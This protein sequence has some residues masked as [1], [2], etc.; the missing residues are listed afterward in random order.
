MNQ[1][2]KVSSLVSRDISNYL[3]N[4]QTW[5]GI[6][7]NVKSYG[8]VGDGST[9][10]TA[11]IVRAIDAAISSGGTVFF[12]PGTFIADSTSLRVTIPAGGNFVMA[13]AGPQSI[14]KRKSGS[15]TGDNQ[16]L[17]NITT[18]TSD[19]D[20]VSVRDLTFDSNATGNP[21]PGGA[22][23]YLWEHCA[24]L[25]VIGASSSAYINHVDLHNVY[26]EDPVAD[27]LYFPGEANS[28]VRT[29]NISHIYAA[30]RTRTRSDITIT[31]GMEVLNIDNIVVDRLEAELNAAY[32]GTKRFVMNVSNARINQALEIAGHTDTMIFNGT[33]IVAANLAV[34]DIRGKISNSEFYH[35]K[36]G[37]ELRFN[38]IR[39]LSFDNVTFYVQ[40]NDDNTINEIRIYHDTS[41]TE[42]TFD[43]VRFLV[44]STASGPFTGY[45]LHVNAVATTANSKVIVRNCFFDAKYT[46]NIYCDRADVVIMQH[47][48]YGGSIYP[49]LFQAGVGFKSDF[50]VIGGRFDRVVTAGGV[51]F[52]FSGSPTVTFDLF[53]PY[54]HGAFSASS[55]AYTSSVLQNNRVLLVSLT[56]TGGGFVGDIAR[57]ITPVSGS[58]CEWQALTSSTSASTWAMTKQAGVK[59][60]TTANRPTPNAID[61]GLRYQ[62]T[63]L[64]ADGKQIEWNGSAWI[65]ATGA[66]V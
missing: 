27:H 63:T 26:F 42:M 21:L 14:L 55:G 59:K 62:D 52:R 20:V 58:A 49:I 41:P 3:T 54:A 39:G 28:Y 16:Y 33:N 38:F 2:Q 57:L 45:A 29:S 7:V 65:D 43:N 48:D 66:V 22:D 30:G 56:P 64:D 34:G 40:P 18:G 36:T 6:I 19:A 47:N 35:P 61:I 8:A 10:D 17:L 60:N 46:N 44:D 25:R 13:G 15:I 53:I 32:D 11:A 4:L 23:P 12:P 1:M 50:Y 51:S 24:T 37:G 9:D 5:G 31:G